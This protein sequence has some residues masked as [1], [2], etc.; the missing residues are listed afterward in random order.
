[1]IAVLE[2]LIDWF[3]RNSGVWPK[4]VASLTWKSN[5]EA[6]E[7]LRCGQGLTGGAVHLPLS[8]DVHDLNSRDDNPGAPK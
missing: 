3:C 2:P 1:M 7:L 5:C 6:L 4:R 8:D